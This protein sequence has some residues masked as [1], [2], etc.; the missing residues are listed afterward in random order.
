MNKLKQIVNQIKIS[1]SKE[2]VNNVNLSSEKAKLSG[3]KK[4]QFH[5]LDF[6]DDF[7]N[8]FVLGYN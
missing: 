8:S 7:S 5:H 1:D 3:E 4:K 6:T 2:E